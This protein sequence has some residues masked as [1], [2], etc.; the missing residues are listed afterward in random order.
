MAT[1]KSITDLKLVLRP[2]QIVAQLFIVVRF[3]SD[4]IVQV[5]YFVYLLLVQVSINM[6]HIHC[7]HSFFHKLDTLI[8]WILVVLSYFLRDQFGT[9]HVDEER[10]CVL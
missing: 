3:L 7:F 2:I 1:V 8:A 5:F 4:D 10:C 9:T 6:M